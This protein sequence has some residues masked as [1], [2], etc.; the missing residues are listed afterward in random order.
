[1]PLKNDWQN[2]DLFT[3]AAA[4]DMANVVNAFGPPT[5]TGQAVVT[6]A[7]AAAA[8]AALKLPPI[9]QDI[10][11]W[12]DSLTYC[13][14]TVSVQ[15][16]PTWPQTLAT[17]LGVNVY[18]GGQGAHGSAEIATRQGG[19]QP[20]CTLT[21]NQIP[22]GST[23]PINLT[24]ISPTD[25]WRS[26]VSSGSYL[27]MH[28]TLA[29][30]AGN[31]RHDLT[32]LALFQF[33]P[34]AAPATTVSVSAATPF[35]G[36]EGAALRDRLAIIWAGQNNS[37]QPSAILRDIASMVAYLNPIKRFVVIN[38]TG[39]KSI[40]DTINPLLQA[41][42]GRNYVD[43]R[44][45]LI[46]DA[47]TALGMS[48]TGTDSSDIAAGNPP[49]SLTWDGT[50]YT[51]S[52]Y[53]LIGQY[54]ARVISSNT[55]QTAGDI[56]V[57]VDQINDSAGN[58][59]IDI[60]GVASAANHLAVGTTA[61]GSSSISLSATGPDSNLT[62]Q[63]I[64]KGSGSVQL[65]AGAGETPRLVANSP[66]T[67]ANLRLSPKGTGSVEIGNSG[68]NNYFT[69]TGSSTAVTLTATGGSSNLAIALI[70]KG[71]GTVEVGAPGGFVPTVSANSPATNANLRLLPKGTGIVDVPTSLYANTTIELGNASDTT[72][73]RSAAGK[74]AVE[75]V[76]VL[77]NG[78]ALGEPS[79]A[80]LTN[81]TGLPVSG[82]TA[83]T[84]TA[85]GVGTIELGHASDTTIARSSAG[86]VTIEGAQIATTVDTL[87]PDELTTGESTLVRRMVSSSAVPTTNGTMRLTYFT[88]RK[89]ETVTQIRTI[90]GA[91][92]QVGATLCRVGIYSVDGS[93][94]LTLVGS[95]ANDTTLWVAASTAYTRSLSASFTK[96]RGQ[97][98]AV[99]VLVV[100]SS[101]AP[102]M[103][104]HL[105]LVTSE[106]V[107]APRLA[108]FAAS[109]TDLP[110][111]V[112]VG[113]V[114]DTAAMSYTVLLP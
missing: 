32:N 74:L 4:N 91:T 35:I 105:S 10:A 83:S 108:G 42:Y 21:G 34:D 101:T 106:A 109:Q 82:I 23:A 41:A 24:A 76:D 39:P 31:L 59:A 72:L 88:A 40:A 100:G 94:N 71:T 17:A 56:T 96:T 55:G 73:S 95:I 64:P 30:V 52:V 51:Q 81:A 18:N 33:V 19:L 44:R 78:G 6:A 97:R 113:S 60:N 90:S 49:N 27:D 66:D 22:A 93:G 47:L 69:S 112:S 16:S 28:G 43:L 87:N 77:L 54:L 102:T 38:Y 20:L 61:A 85:L 50:H 8:R 29:G 98:Y 89:T 9:P 86:V 114:L 68:S 26:T 104:G 65:W 79:S 25:G 7:N 63:L 12:G 99:A 53:N 67:N 70:P 75:G 45:F 1:M 15:A 14:V 80:T 11:C 3:P 5:E 110:A 13:P 37:D 107:V 92:A 36:D 84:S 62:M 48:P 103:L 46:N 2:G 58:P 111:T 57:G